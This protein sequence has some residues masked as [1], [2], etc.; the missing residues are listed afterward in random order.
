M[1]S[2]LRY[3]PWTSAQGEQPALKQEVWKSCH[4]QR[5]L[6]GQFV[7]NGSCGIDPH[8]SSTW[9]TVVCW[10][11]TYNQFRKVGTPWEG[12][13]A[14]AREE[15]DHDRMVEMEHYELIQLL[16]LLIIGNM[17]YLSPYVEF[18]MPGLVTDEWS[19]CPYFSPWALFCIVFSPLLGMGSKRVVVVQF[20]CQSGWNYHTF[21]RKCY[22][23][24][25]SEW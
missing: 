1:E 20:S 6:L 24:C 25:C 3:R 7:K 22:A 12:P 4:Q 19:P 9:R 16:S 11:I 15:R 5:P 2:H 17:L 18:V 13:H 23:Y 14:G 10:K 8:W 21:T